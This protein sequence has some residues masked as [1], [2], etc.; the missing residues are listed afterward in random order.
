MRVGTIVKR[1]APGSAEIVDIVATPPDQLFITGKRV[2]ETTLAV[3]TNDGEVI[4]Y[5]IHVTYPV[6]AINTAL[7]AS[8]RN[9][10]DVSVLPAGTSLVLKGEVQA[11]GDV[12]RA[13]EIVRGYILASLPA[14]TEPPPIINMLTVPG[15]HQVQIEVSFAE[16]SRT[17]LREVGVNFWMR[18]KQTSTVNPSFSGGITSPATVT[19]G[20]GVASGLDLPNGLPI[21][22]QPMTGAFGMVFATAADSAFP[23]T[24]ALSLLSSRGY[25]RTLSE[26]T[27]VAMSGE[28]ATFL[29][30]GE[31]PIPIPQ[32]LGVISVE[33]KKFG[34]QL[35]FRPIVMGDTIQLHMAASVSDIDSTIGLR[36][37][38][39]TVPGLTTRASETTVRLRDGQSFAIAGL[40]SDRV[41]SSVDKLPFLG[42]VPVLGMLFRSTSYRREETELLIVVTARIARPQD[43]RPRLPAEDMTTDP[44]DLELFFLGTHESQQNEKKTTAPAPTGA[45]GFVR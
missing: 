43:K 21:L 15:D 9:A 25:A 7:R 5:A 23:F 29:A 1:V 33:Y 3:W 6:E 8:L 40:L 41:R 16:V 38:G 31:F 34:I 20:A 24:A 19:T 27:L 32:G 13:E 10:K 26:P 30:G 17:A 45:V 2:G 12:T 44:S 39:V 22:S 18:D 35:G 36:L 42:D 14:G 37:E 4:V 11:A 28:E